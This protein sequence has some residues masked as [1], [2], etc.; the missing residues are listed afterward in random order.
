MLRQVYLNGHLAA[1]LIG[2]IS[3]SSHWLRFPRRDFTPL[4]SCC[5]RSAQF[6]LLI[7]LLTGP[8]D[9]IFSYLFNRREVRNPLAGQALR[10]VSVSG[11]SPLSTFILH[12][13]H[14]F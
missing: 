10:E 8:Q 14:A 3:D 4:G 2:H 1:L 7:K 12:A 11:S 13:P 9:R 5:H 6:T